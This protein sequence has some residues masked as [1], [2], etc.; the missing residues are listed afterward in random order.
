MQN[1]KVACYIITHHAR[2]KR[3]AWD[4]VRSADPEATKIEDL[5][6]DAFLVQQSEGAEP[7]VDVFNREKPIFIQHLAPVQARATDLDGTA[8]TDFDKLEQAALAAAPI[9]PETAFGIQCRKGVSTVS[10]THKD[11]AYGSRDVEVAVGTRLELRG[12]K[13]NPSAYTQVLSIYLSGTSGYVGVSLASENL[14]D[15]ADEH[16]YRSL[17]DTQ[18]SR[19]EHKLSEALGVFGLT[20]NAGT[21]ALDL[22][23]APGGWTNVLAQLGAHV[24]AV[25]PGALDPVLADNPLVDHRRERIENLVF[26]PGSF[27]LV[28]NDMNLEPWESAALMCMVAPWAAEGSDAVMTIKMMKGHPKRLIE[29][30]VAVLDHAYEVVGIRH[31]HHNRQ[32]VT[33]HLRRKAGPVSD[34]WQEFIIEGRGQQPAKDEA[35]AAEGE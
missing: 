11:A 14:T 29:R 22:G 23:A 8:E 35:A 9:D 28:V 2:F 1:P 31:L 16:R 19:A 27:D 26:E 18:I 24:V 12:L 32:E 15:R 17:T 20:V 7:L 6:V 3:S 10:G 30:G 34:G 25:D 33:A 21:R 5:D 13:A 4:E